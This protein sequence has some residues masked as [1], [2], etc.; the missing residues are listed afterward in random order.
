MSLINRAVFAGRWYRDD[1]E[2]LDRDLH[3][4]RDDAAVAQRTFSDHRTLRGAVLPHAGIDFSGRGISH[5]FQGNA[6]RSADHVLVLS[7]SHYVSLK[8]DRLYVE[9]FDEHETPLGPLPGLPAFSAEL[10]RRLPDL[11]VADNRSIEREHGTE[12]FLPFVRKWLGPVPVSLVLVPHFTAPEVCPQWAQA[13][14]DSLNSVDP[15]RTVVIMSSDFTHYGRRFGYT[16]F[17]IPRA[18]SGGKVEEAVRTDDLAFADMIVR[19]DAAAMERRM[20]RPITVCGRHSI[21]LGM[22]LIQR[23][24]EPGGA[25]SGSA[26]RT[27]RRVVDYY[28]SRT[29]TGQADSDFVCYGTVFFEEGV[30][31]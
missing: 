17:G 2:L 11:T 14:A 10:A 12:M 23:L 30:V 4:F 8:P 27:V 13:I 19:G 18:S 6:A 29:V 7:P 25:E 9:T 3:Q 5:A 21:R 24:G 28:N 16:P 20:S 15:G 22:E 1:P 26:G 31:S